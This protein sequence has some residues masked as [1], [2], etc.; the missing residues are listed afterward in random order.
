VLQICHDHPT[1]KHGLLALGSLYEE[2]ETAGSSQNGPHAAE[3][4]LHDAFALQQYNKAVSLLAADISSPDPPIESI[5]AT[6]LI[7]VFLEFLRNNI[8][9]ALNHLKAGLRILDQSISIKDSSASFSSSKPQ[10]RPVDDSL[11]SLFKDLHSQA[12]IHGYPNTDVSSSA[13]TLPTLQFS[14]ELPTSLS[15]IADA[16]AALENILGSMFQLVRQIQNTTGFDIDSSHPEAMSTAARD[17]VAQDYLFRL[18]M[19]FIAFEELLSQL[20]RDKK[21]DK[22]QDIMAAVLRLHYLAVSVSLKTLPSDNEMLFDFY[23]PDFSQ[24][25]DLATMLVDEL[26]KEKGH[27]PMLSMDMGII[28]PLFVVAWK[29]RDAGVRRRAMEL[30]KRAPVREGIWSRESTLKFAGWKVQ[31]EENRAREM[32]WTESLGEPLPQQARVHLEKLVQVEGIDGKK[33]TMIK[34]NRKVG[35]V[36]EHL[37]EVVD[38]GIEMGDII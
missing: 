27:F 35:H 13:L 30:L 34:Y 4:E 12:I 20:K 18:S 32:G 7:F 19:W 8:P 15:N 17:A 24:I 5:L 9:A 1:V 25:V 38:M 14:A 29:C 26:N 23:T 36:T 6:C 28:G 11:V 3:V 37:E 22:K 2:Y 16:T 31:R 33:V 10:N 21:S